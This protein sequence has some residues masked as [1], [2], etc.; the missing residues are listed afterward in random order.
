MQPA[1]LL[2][3]VVRRAEGGL[4][5]RR[6]CLALG[7]L[8]IVSAGLVVV[9][10]LRPTAGPASGINRENFDRVREGMTEAE[11]EAI[12]GCPPGHYNRRPVVVLMSGVMF[13]RWWVSDDAVI[14]IEL[15]PDDA[16]WE[17]PWRV[18]HKDYWPVPPE[19]LVDRCWRL[20]PTW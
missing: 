2:N 13:R 16:D 14:T 6:F 10:L 20:L 11:V 4:M 17:R 18:C 1:P 3:C 19:S 15:S 9:C 8:A 7:A 5:G 12:F